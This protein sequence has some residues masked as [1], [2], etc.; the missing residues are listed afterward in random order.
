M[1][2]FWSPGTPSGSR[3]WRGTPS[4]T[5]R[6]GANPKKSDLVNFWGPDWRKFSELRVLL[7]FLGK[8]DKMFPKSR[9]SKP[10]CGH[11]AGSPKLDRPCCKRFWAIWTQILESC[12][13]SELDPPPRLLLGSVK[14]GCMAKKGFSSRTFWRGLSVTRSGGFSY[15]RRDEPSNRRA[16]TRM[17]Y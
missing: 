2:L 11:S 8:T 17:F 14:T 16:S 5:R 12:W 4:G 1:V 13:P 7:F 10:I 3:F 6:I 15:I 9:F